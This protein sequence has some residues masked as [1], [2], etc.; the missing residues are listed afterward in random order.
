MEVLLLHSEEDA[1]IP[2]GDV[3][4][5]ADRLRGD[6]GWPS[7]RRECWRGCGHVELYRTFPERYRAALGTLGAV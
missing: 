5:F 4:A 1:L 7:V 2:P 6:W 3:A